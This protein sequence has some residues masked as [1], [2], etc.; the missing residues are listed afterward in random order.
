VTVLEVLQ[1]W[2]WAVPRYGG[3]FLTVTAG[4][5]WALT[6]NAPPP[7]FLVLFGGMMCVGETGATLKKVGGITVTKD[8]R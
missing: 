7:G 6:G 1:A 4:A 5:I 8:D 2:W 3:F